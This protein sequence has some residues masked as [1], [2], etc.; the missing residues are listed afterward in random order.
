MPETNLPPLRIHVREDLPNEDNLVD[1][2]ILK[3]QL[4]ELPEQ[5]RERLK[6][7]LKISP[8]IIVALMVGLI[9]LHSNKC[10]QKI[11]LIFHIFL[12]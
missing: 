8:A 1:A 10:V 6:N 4:P 2:V 11:F 12:E 5:I 7:D 9:A 3:K